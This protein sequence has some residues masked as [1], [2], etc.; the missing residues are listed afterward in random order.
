MEHDGTR[1]TPSA[2]I[3]LRASRLHAASHVWELELVGHFGVDWVGGV[4]V[5]LRDAASLLASHTNRSG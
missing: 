3:A 4:A 2:A 5:E 1:F